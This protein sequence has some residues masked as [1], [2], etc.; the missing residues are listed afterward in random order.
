[1]PK[2]CPN[3]TRVVRAADFA[4][5]PEN[6]RLMITS[7]IEIPVLGYVDAV[8]RFADASAWLPADQA[9]PVHV[10][11]FEAL[12]WLHSLVVGARDGAI[13]AAPAKTL[14][15]DPYVKSLTFVRGRAHHHW[16][17]AIYA[18]DT[19]EWLWQGLGVLPPAPAGHGGRRGQKASRTCLERKPV[20]ASLQ[21]VERLLPALDS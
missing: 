20:V 19:G 2:L 9:Q 3:E 16:A 14:L 5:A 6:E 15:G 8:R 18:N 13:G 12:N 11:L 4:Y 1:V 21:H 7:G 17:Q 10:A